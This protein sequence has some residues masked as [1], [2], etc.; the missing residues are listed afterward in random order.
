MNHLPTLLALTAAASFGLA[1]VMV[2]KGHR[3][4]DSYTGTA[5]SITSTAML[6]WLTLPLWWQEATWVPW[7]VGMWAVVGL[8]N[9]AVS[10][11]LS[12]EG[13]RLLGH[14]TSATLAATVPVFSAVGA[15]LFLGE[16]LTTPLLIGTALVVPGAMLLGWQPAHARTFAWWAVVLPLGSAAIRA[17]GQ[18]VTKHGL[19]SLPSP[20]M[21]ALVPFSVSVV[22]IHL[23]VRWR[24]R[25]FPPAPQSADSRQDRHMGQR[26]FVGVGTLNGLGFMAMNQAVLQ[27]QLVQV[28]PLVA[29]FPLFALLFSWVLK[30]AVG[31]RWWQTVGVLMAV[32]GVMV[33][34]GG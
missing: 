25:Q 9:P 13:N 3:Y 15:I 32:A 26:W 30:E 19:E 1:V 23:W 34:S 22:V 7:V 2:K 16:H 6:F 31:L 18:L 11:L 24:A 27:G 29:T 14:A 33:V 21:A 17:S 4:T 28:A 20:M 10:L 5:T 12:F 8:L